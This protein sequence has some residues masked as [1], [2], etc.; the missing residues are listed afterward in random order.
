MYDGDEILMLTVGDHIN[1]FE[2]IEVFVIWS[3][4][5]DYSLISYDLLFHIQLKNI[6]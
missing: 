2:A 4:L 3:L 6:G 5:P 1:I